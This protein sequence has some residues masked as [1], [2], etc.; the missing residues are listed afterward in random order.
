[1]EMI[2]VF[3]GTNGDGSATPP[4]LS[5]LM[6]V[7]SGTRIHIKLRWILLGVKSALITPAA[8]TH[9]YI[10]SVQLLANTLIRTGF[11]KEHSQE[12][13]MDS[14]QATKFHYIHQDIWSNKH[15]HK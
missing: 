4:G 6:A 14:T 13:L 1:M 2:F 9:F 8:Q 7:S 15:W 10:P 3:G 11:G 5:H 12:L